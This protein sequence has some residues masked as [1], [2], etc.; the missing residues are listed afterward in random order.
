MSKS[1]TVETG[2][3]LISRDV[4]TTANLESTLRKGGFQVETYCSFDSFLTT[5]T[6]DFDGYVVLDVR[7]SSIDLLDFLD[8]LASDYPSIH[9][10]L[11]AKEGFV[12][13]LV[14]AV[15]AGR[16]DLLEQ[17]PRGEAANTL[18]ERLSR[19]LGNP[20]KTQ[21]PSTDR[22]PGRKSVGHRRLENCPRGERG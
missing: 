1:E 9:C 21:A 14:R 10:L 17:A 6:A 15:K 20:K 7:T 12:S 13:S 16:V 5:K 4:R 2:V 19:S 8:Q 3:C 22:N 11:I 18:L